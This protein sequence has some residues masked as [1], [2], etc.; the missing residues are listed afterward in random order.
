M[1]SR[2]GKDGTAKVYFRIKEGNKK[3][4]IF[5]G[6]RWPTEFFDR[7]NQH[8]LP[9]RKE[10]PDVKA[11]NLRINEYK[12]MAHRYELNGFMHGT[13]I[14]FE[15]LSKE[16][17]AVGKD[18]D[19]FTFMLFEINKAYN[20]DIVTY[21]TWKRHRS[22]LN[23]I[24]KF[25]DKPALNI[26]EIDSEFIR[27]FDAWA[28]K[29]GKSHNTV[30]GYHKDFKNY[31]SKAVDRMLISRNPYK[32]FKFAYVDGDREAL[33]QEDLK[34]LL[35]LFK[36]GKLPENEEEILRRFLF[37]CF[38]GLR[39]SDTDQ[40]HEDMLS[41]RMLSF[42][43]FKGRKKGKRLIVPL[44]DTA[45]YLIQ[46]RTGLIF[47]P[48]SHSYINETLKIIGARAGIFKRVT[49]H[50][51]RDTFGTIMI[52]RGADIKSVKELMGHENLSTTMIYLKMSDK[53]KEKLVKNLD[54]IFEED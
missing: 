10:D 39:I 8:L 42:I 32:D 26:H 18:K 25:H 47:K 14:S 33:S 41:G 3:K 28:R 13:E 51:S 44:S 40:L 34:S 5:T 52:E 12:A 49:Y 43:P 16:F 6:V 19:F 17:K 45:M 1:D 46:G 23:Q 24:K 2:E 54:A 21:L 22:S 38:S 50:M 7:I 11:Y 36:S 4:D 9:R 37:S 27:R 31:L 15:N 48:Y 29:E 20:N 35:K 53:R 30:C